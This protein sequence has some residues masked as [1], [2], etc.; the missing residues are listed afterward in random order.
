MGNEIHPAPVEFNEDQ[1]KNDPIL[2]YFHY[3]HLPPLLQLISGPFCE[4]ADRCVRLLPRNAERS[5]ALRKLLEAKDAAVRA[6]VE[7]IQKPQ[8]FIDRLKIEFEELRG[9]YTNLAA[10]LETDDYRQLGMEDQRLLS[11]QLSRMV[12]YLDVLDKRIKRTDAPAVGFPVV[13]DVKIVGGDKSET[14]VPFSDDVNPERKKI[15]KLEH[16]NPE[17]K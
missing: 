2:R 13:G 6:N 3:L 12:Q 16:E 15:I 17:R 1:L 14:P 11:I 9:R 10:F 7:A 5:V 4:L 8:S